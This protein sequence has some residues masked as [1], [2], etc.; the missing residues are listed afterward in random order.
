MRSSR[1]NLSNGM[2]RLCLVIPILILGL[3]PPAGSLDL[4]AG[5]WVYLRR[6]TPPASNERLVEVIA[7]GDVMPGRGLA[8]TPGLF[9]RVAG[10]LQGADLAIGNLEGVMAVDSSTGLTPSLY[11]PPG[12]AASLAEA[13]FDMLGLANN[14]ALDAGPQ[15]LAET[16]SHL[17]AAGLQ[18][19]ES[20]RPV[21]REIDSLKIAF[22]AGNEI[23]SAGDD[24]L[25][26]ALRAVRPS[27]DIVIILLH[28]GQ[29][30]QRHPNQAQRE[31]AGELLAAGADIVLGSHPHV[32]QDLQVIHPEDAD[33]RPRLVAYSLGNFVFDQGWDDTGQG[34][35]LRLLFDRSGLRAAQALPLRTAPR[36]RWMAPGEATDLLERILPVERSGFACLPDSCRP[37]QVPQERRSGL[38]W[39]GAIDLTGDGRPEI[40]RR[41]GPAVEIYQDGQPAWRSPPEWRVLDLALG[42]PNDDGRYELLLALEKPTPSGNLTNHPFILGYRGGSYRLLW[43]GS[44]VSDPLRE[45]ELGDLDGDGVAEL[46][47]IEASPDGSARYVTVWRWH[48]WGFSLL[49][50]SP[51]GEYHDLTIL[52]AGDGL[53]TR[54][55]VSAAP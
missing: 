18:P 24:A 37:V 7:V 41:Q 38:L 13:G 32:V 50:R 16:A 11:L 34:L 19:L 5:P 17:Q 23:P 12:T 8:A 27:A 25:L 30:Y 35:A 9:D 2:A 54:L 51:P 48:G 47:V 29:E 53:P 3:H 6:D 10:E 39:S 26:A 46:A 15:G 14:H 36:P 43:G 55:S 45:V 1:Q 22:L 42:D 28:W 21:V 31:L 33:D 52:P 20:A 44:P 49:W 40:V 4:A